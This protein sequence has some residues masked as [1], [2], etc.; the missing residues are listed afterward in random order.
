MAPGRSALC[1]HSLRRILAAVA[2]LALLWQGL[3]WRCFVVLH[4]SSL[5]HVRSESA[6]TIRWSSKR[7]LSPTAERAIKAT[8]VPQKTFLESHK[9]YAGPSTVH[10]WGVFA[11]E[12]CKKGETLHEAPGRFVPGL[13]EGLGD[14]VFESKWVLGEEEGKNTSILAFGFGSLHNH[15]ED[16]NVGVE[17]QM[18]REHGKKLVGLFYALKDIQ[19][20]D[21]LFISYGPKW[22]SAR[23]ITLK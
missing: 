15:A 6:R 21:E 4:Q 5:W 16:P 10:G 1:R 23:N 14:D 19:R 17:W 13:P 22:F 8:E 11:I 18:P 20:G 3:A 12:D 2:A 7:E 9:V